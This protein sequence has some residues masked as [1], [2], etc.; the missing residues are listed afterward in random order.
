MVSIGVPREGWGCGAVP[1]RTEWAHR[2]HGAASQL[3]PANSWRSARMKARPTTWA[4]TRMI[5]ARY[6]AC[7]DT[8]LSQPPRL[9][10]PVT[11]PRALHNPGSV[12]SPHPWGS[13]LTPSDFCHGRTWPC[14]LFSVPVMPFPDPVT[15]PGPLPPPVPVSPVPMPC[16]FSAGPVILSPVPA[17]LPLALSSLLCPCHPSP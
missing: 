16:P 6:L 12:T 14:P 13:A 15:S 17:P 7:G 1:S 8:L 5:C 11:F 10:C 2:A 4:P 9:L 3:L